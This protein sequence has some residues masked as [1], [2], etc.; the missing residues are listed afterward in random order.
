MA[1]LLDRVDSPQD[2]KGIPPGDLPAL[3]AEIRSLILGT[4]LQTGGHLATNLGSVEL[5]T[6]LHYVYDAPRD[7]LVFDV[8][9]QVYA[10][11]ILTGRKSRIAT[12]RQE[13]GL[14]GFS[15]REESPYDLFTTGHAGTALSTALGLACGEKVRGGTARTV[16]VI[17][18]AGIGAGMA[19][20]A[21]NMAGEVK[22][23]LLVVLNDN[24]MSIAPSNGAM[25]GYFTRLRTNPSYRKAKH[26]VAEAVERIF[27]GKAREAAEHWYHTL[28]YAVVP[29]HL[30]EEL[31]FHYFGPVDGHDVQTLVRELRD[32]RDVGGPRLLHVVT[33][34]GHGY[35]PARQDPVKFH[36]VKP[37]PKKPAPA[38]DVKVPPAAAPQVSWTRAFSD[39]LCALAEEDPRVVAITAAMPDGTGLDRFA[40][41]FPA[42]TFDV[43]I[44][45]QNAVGLAGGLAA[46][47]VLPVAAI[48]STFLQRGYDQVFHEVALQGR[49]A[50]LAL[51]RAGIVGSDGVSHTGAFDIAFL[52]TLPNMI[53]MAP[54]DGPELEA[55][56]RFAAREPGIF[57]LRYPRDEVP[58]AIRGGKAPPVV[59]GKAEVLR[60]GPDAGILAYGASVYPAW[61]AARALRHRGI[62]ATVVNMRFA[63]PLDAELVLRLHRELPFLVTVEDHAVQG[64]FG[65]AVLECL[66]GAGGAEG[67]AAPRVR[68][69]GIPDAYLDHAERDRLLARFGL[70]AAGIAAAV[71]E[72]AGS[73]DRAAHP[74]PR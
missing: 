73:P 68:M 61:C 56:L 35:E 49:K 8:G 62:R 45:E 34:K 33:E 22:R 69:L 41:R 32:L 10:H 11:K 31:G 71:L 4:V 18:D 65:S 29:G 58:P 67:T 37:S 48:Y 40:A 28:R 3:C 54:K 16:A 74:R 39:A 44:C 55:M 63:K 51:D 66:A 72:M 23:D 46:A 24:R 19:F 20:E 57:A 52:R 70:D 1:S 9:H 6:A 25:V 7:H 15:N 12:L 42:R 53:L 43:G 59:L 5:I 47:G 64:G 14:S 38:P 26:D 60:R 21:L 50:I 13:G 27:G 17:G 2:L 30:F 36:G